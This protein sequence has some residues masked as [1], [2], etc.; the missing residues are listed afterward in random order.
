MLV[1]DEMLGKFIFVCYGLEEVE[2]G[3]LRYKELTIPE[4]L[5][6]IE[7][8]HKQYIPMLSYDHAEYEPCDI[9]NIEF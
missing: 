6:I 9:D 8:S 3:I 4:V 7:H 1:Y 2:T 5:Y